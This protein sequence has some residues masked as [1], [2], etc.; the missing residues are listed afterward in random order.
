[1]ASLLFS[2]CR[3]PRSYSPARTLDPGYAAGGY[4]P[5]QS[6]Y[7]PSQSGYAASQSG[8][9]PS[10]SGYAASQSGQ[11]Y[12]QGYASQGQG[13]PRGQSSTSGYQPVY[14]PR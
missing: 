14:Q 2:V 7:A 4:A 10:Q 6:G 11:G 9:A 13:R 8:Y 3:P 1:M 5:S 12:G